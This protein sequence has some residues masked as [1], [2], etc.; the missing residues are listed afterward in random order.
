[1]SPS[2]DG[3]VAIA[4]TD[5]TRGAFAAPHFERRYRGALVAR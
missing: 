2:K 1:M 4:A 3:S 5:A